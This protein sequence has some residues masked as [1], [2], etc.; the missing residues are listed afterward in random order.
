MLFLEHR[1]GKPTFEHKKQV[2]LGPN[3]LR[4]MEANV[5][6]TLEDSTLLDSIRDHMATDE[7]T[8]D[9]LDHIIPDRASW[10]QSKNPRND[11]RQFYWHGGFLF[12]ENL[13]YVRNG[14]ARLQVLQ[15]CHD[16]QMARQFG[17]RKTL[18]LVSQQ[19]W[20]P[21][22]RQRVCSQL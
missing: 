19:Y 4:L 20:W 21:R 10:S 17:V 22:L 7:F 8:N 12:R 15:H 2:L 3:R 13:L 14:R 6:T 9:V 18:E 16:T 1:P 11:Y 5:I